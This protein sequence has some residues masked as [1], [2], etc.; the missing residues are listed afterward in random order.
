MIIGRDVVR[1][2]CNNLSKLAGSFFTVISLLKLESE[3]VSRECIV[4]VRCDELFKHVFARL[5]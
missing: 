3:R 1:I 4:R 2:A 5:H